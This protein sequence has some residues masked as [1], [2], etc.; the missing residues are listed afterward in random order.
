MV[1]PQPRAHTNISEKQAC[2]LP[3]SPLFFMQAVID[4]VYYDP[5]HDPTNPG[6]RVRQYFPAPNQLAVKV[7]D[8]KQE[9]MVK[10]GNELLEADLIRHDKL[11]SLIELARLPDVRPASVLHHTSLRCHRTG[12]CRSQ[13][14]M[15]ARFRTA[16]ATSRTNSRSSSRTKPF[17][18]PALIL[19]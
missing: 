7:E 6:Q 4:I 10:L 13:T 14:R 2:P 9:I 11:T 8:V 3:T 5:F 17:G 15:V 19:T 16:F 1:E 12:V 18:H